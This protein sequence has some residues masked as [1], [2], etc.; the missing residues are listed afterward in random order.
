MTDNFSRRVELL[1]AGQLA[2]E[3][4][5]KWDKQSLTGCW[6]LSLFCLTNDLLYSRAVVMPFDLIVF[7]KCLIS[8][9]SFREHFEH[10]SI[11]WTV[12]CSTEN[13][14]THNLQNGLSL[15]VGEFEV[16]TRLRFD[17]KMLLYY[18]G[19]F[20]NQY[21]RPYASFQSHK[22]RVKTGRSS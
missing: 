22:L 20:F 17:I 7:I 6:T 5:H 19:F 13:I 16:T 8:Y 21:L 14:K 15:L 10:S 9:D 18:L 12:L 11:L 3:T 1:V 4:S 2:E